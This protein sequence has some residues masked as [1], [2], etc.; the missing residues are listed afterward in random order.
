MTVGCND[1]K[2]SPGIAGDICNDFKWCP[3][4]DDYLIQESWLDRLFRQ[5]VQFPF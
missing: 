1:D 3:Q 4:L 2:I 5:I